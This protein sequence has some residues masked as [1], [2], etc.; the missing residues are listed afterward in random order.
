MVSK[1]QGIDYHGFGRLAGEVR[2]VMSYNCEGDL[3]RSLFDETRK[4]AEA[5]SETVAQR[6]ARD[7]CGVIGGGLA[8][9]HCGALGM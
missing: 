4:S 3:V 5:K 7:S 1:Y 8:A 6:P 2:N 9:A